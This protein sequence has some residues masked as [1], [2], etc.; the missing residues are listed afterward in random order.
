MSSPEPPHNQSYQTPKRNSGQRGSSDSRIQDNSQIHEYQSTVSIGSIS[1]NRKKIMRYVGEDAHSRDGNVVS[2][3]DASGNVNDGTVSLTATTPIPSEQQAD[4]VQREVDDVNKQIQ[5][6]ISKD[7]NSFVPS[8][9][10]SS[11]SKSAKRQSSNSGFSSRTKRSESPRVKR[12]PG[13]LSTSKKHQ[14]FSGTSSGT[15]DFNLHGN[16][17]PSNSEENWDFSRNSSPM[18]VAHENGSGYDDNH[19]SYDDAAIGLHQVQRGTDDDHLRSHFF[20]GEERNVC[21]NLGFQVVGA[22]P[23]AHSPGAFIGQDSFFHNSYGNNSISR[24]YDDS[25]RR[26]DNADPHHSP[27]QFSYLDHEG[28]TD[29]NHPNCT[30][31]AAVASTAEFSPDIRACIR[32]SPL[33][34]DRELHQPA[35]ALSP[36]KANSV[37]IGASATP[38]HKSPHS[39]NGYHSRHLAFGEENAFFNLNHDQEVT[40]LSNSNFNHSNTSS[41]VDS[42]ITSSNS[43]NQTPAGSKRG[44]TIKKSRSR[45]KSPRSTTSPAIAEHS[46]DICIGDNKVE[47]NQSGAMRLFLPGEEES[48]FLGAVLPIKETCNPDSSEVTRTSP[49]REKSK[50]DS[51]KN[52]SSTSVSPSTASPAAA[53][54][55]AVHQDLVPPYR[56][57]TIASSRESF[58]TNLTTSLPLSQS[59]TPAERST[60]DRQMNRDGGL[61]T[62]PSTRHNPSTHSKANGEGNRTNCVIS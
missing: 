22:A 59:V 31:S 42:D 34:A 17:N 10:T 57:V 60:N 13:S 44:L 32:A 7:R 51:K 8:S 12:P 36:S 21:S 11:P 26:A 1:T 48:Q 24:Q 33:L 18:K 62:T 29:R 39:L 47:G 16:D 46:Q 35:V 50:K 9:T 40:N 2:S 37:C 27:E 4:N 56:D 20:I 43:N 6:G 15:F 23:P 58:V 49:R 28:A 5:S 38:T 45:S 30:V 14:S 52:G 3:P 61:R 54:F 19:Q 41:D 53:S 25:A 55:T